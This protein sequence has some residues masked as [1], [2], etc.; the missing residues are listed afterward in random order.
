[1]SHTDQVYYKFFYSV[2]EETTHKHLK[3][4]TA[5]SLFSNV[6]LIVTTCFDKCFNSM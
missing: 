3:V 1:M 2:G 4:A 5:K 6:Y